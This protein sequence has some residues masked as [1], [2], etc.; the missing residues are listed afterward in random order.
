MRSLGMPR[1]YLHDITVFLQR[2]QEEIRPRSHVMPK[3]ENLD[4]MI[5]VL[6]PWG[7]ERGREDSSC[8]SGAHVDQMEEPWSLSTM[9]H[10]FMA[11]LGPQGLL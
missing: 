1:Q 7:S 8:D 3:A 2:I 9:W 4:F 10:F 6:G 5:P 11:A